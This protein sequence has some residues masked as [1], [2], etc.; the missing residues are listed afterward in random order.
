MNSLKL[1]ILFF[2]LILCSCARQDLESDNNTPDP[3]GCSQQLELSSKK[4]AILTSVWMYYD[5]PQTLEQFIES[6]KL[7]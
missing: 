7:E 2:T 4:R 5:C 3:K 1:V 6:H